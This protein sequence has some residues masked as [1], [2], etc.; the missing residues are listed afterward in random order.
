MY[1]HRLAAS[2]LAP[3]YLLIFDPDTASKVF[4]D[5][6]MHVD[7]YFAG[8][9]LGLFYEDLKRYRVYREP[10]KADMSWPERLK[11]RLIKYITDSKVL[12]YW[13]IGGALVGQN[14]LALT[15]YVYIDL[16][17]YESGI[18]PDDEAFHRKN[19]LLMSLAKFTFVASIFSLSLA[20]LSGQAVFM[21]FTLSNDKMMPFATRVLPEFILLLPIF[22]NSL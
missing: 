17:K 15:Y 21:N 16:D 22:A 18:V 9:F 4:F 12:I 11:F 5:A 14:A 20:V 13:L 2:K 7:S 1:G 6:L 19:A 10:L 8:V 3:G